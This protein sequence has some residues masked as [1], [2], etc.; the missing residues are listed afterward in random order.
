MQLTPEFALVIEMQKLIGLHEIEELEN[1]IA[2]DGGETVVG[3]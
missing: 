2:P 1:K 3:L